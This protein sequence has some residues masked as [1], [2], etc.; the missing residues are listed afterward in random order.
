MVFE[1]LSKSECPDHWRKNWNG[2]I[3]NGERGSRSLGCD[4]ELEPIRLLKPK[5]TPRLEYARRI[6]GNG[7]RALVFVQRRRPI[8]FPSGSTRR[9]AGSLEFPPLAKHARR[10]RLRSIA[11]ILTN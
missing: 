11:T 9:L 3:T 10:V 7:D 1:A 4:Y 5:L 6:K 2:C 8:I